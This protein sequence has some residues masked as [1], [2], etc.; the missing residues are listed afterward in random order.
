MVITEN[1]WSDDGQLNDTDR[2]VYL[3]EHL[4]EVLRAVLDDDC[5]V[6]G[7]TVWSM[8]DNFEWCRGYK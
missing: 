8:V 1:G 7:Y 6:T 5:N 4:H 2:I 3:R